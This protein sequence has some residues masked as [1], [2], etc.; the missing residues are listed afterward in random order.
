MARVISFSIYKGGTGKTTSAVNTAGALSKRGKKVLL[1]DL[2]QQAN[3]TRYVGI[4]PDEINPAFYHVFLKQVPA[5]VVIKHTRFGFDVLPS[6]SLLAAVEESMEPGDEL[7]LREILSPLQDEYDYILIDT[8][9]GKAYL[10]FNGIVAANLLLVPASAERMSIDGVSDLVNHVQEIFWHKFREE[11][12]SQEIRILFTKFKANTKHSPSV[13][14]A[15]IRIYRDNVLST[16]VP[17]AIAFPRSF[18]RRSPLTALEP[19]HPGSLAY[20]EVADWIL[21]HAPSTTS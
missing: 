17:E 2:D 12:Q 4:N 9:P 8:P 19:E 1:V 20:F 18:D 15:A 5:S 10:A 13:V 3:T 11:L 14:Q 6:S 16:F 7:M 21:T